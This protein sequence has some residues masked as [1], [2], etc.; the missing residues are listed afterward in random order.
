M[1][2]PLD[3]ASSPYIVVESPV[4]RPIVRSLSVPTFGLRLR[5]WAVGC[6]DARGRV[7]D[8]LGWSSGPR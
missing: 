8:S 6:G 7:P 5:L 4:I 2:A 3:K 1:E